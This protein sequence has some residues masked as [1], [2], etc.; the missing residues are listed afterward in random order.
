MANREANMQ[1]ETN[2]TNTNQTKQPLETE[3]RY[4]AYSVQRSRED[5]LDACRRAVECLERFA[6]GARR[7]IER[8]AELDPA[9]LAALPGAVLSAGAWGAANAATELSSA[10]QMVAKY[11]QSLARFEALK[12]GA[13]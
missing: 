9:R 12:S 8:G 1:N 6:A 5:I 4:A 7:E 11:M 10:T 13:P 3:L 2:Q